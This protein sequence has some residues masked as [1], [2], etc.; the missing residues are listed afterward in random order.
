MQL[1]SSPSL[2]HPRPIPYGHVSLWAMINCN[3]GLFFIELR[4]LELYEQRLIV[5]LSQSTQ[6]ANKLVD[7]AYGFDPDEWANVARDLNVHLDQTASTFMPLQSNTIPAQIHQLRLAISH[8]PAMGTNSPHLL[9]ALRNTIEIE[10]RSSRFFH[11]PRNKAEMLASL[12][13]EW[14]AQIQ[15]FP[16]IKME[17]VDGIDCFALGHHTACVFHMMRAAEVG[18]RLIAEDHTIRLNKKKPITHAQ[19]GEILDAIETKNKSLQ[20]LKA[21]PQKDKMSAFYSA[22]CS[23]VRALRDKYRNDV[24]HA[25]KRFGESET[26]DAIFHVKSLLNELANNKRGKRTTP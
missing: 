19:W 15:A 20:Q 21:G 11:Y 7:L 17:I 26:G 10:L 6:P 24:M 2:S 3:V 22:L 8:G 1:A 14:A 5:A 9:A 23:H 16:S 25:K 18:I 13:T 12:S 4:M